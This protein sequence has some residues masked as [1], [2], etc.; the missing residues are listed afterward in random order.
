LVHGPAYVGGIIRGQLQVS[1]WDH[2][3]DFAASFEVDLALVF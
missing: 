2:Q 3:V 1:P